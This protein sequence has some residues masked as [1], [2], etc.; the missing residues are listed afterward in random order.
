MAFYDR[1][2]ERIIFDTQG[3]GI[4]F[5]VRIIDSDYDLALFKGRCRRYESYLRRIEMELNYATKEA[6]KEGSAKGKAKEDI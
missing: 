6:H 2:D 1:C 4:R 5:C 3:Q